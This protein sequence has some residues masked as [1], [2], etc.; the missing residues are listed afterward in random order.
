MALIDKL[1]AI[2]DAIR[3]KTGTT[4]PMTLD[5]MVTAIA[6]ITT[7]S[8]PSDT[9]TL[10]D[11]TELPKPTLKDGCNYAI[12]FKNSNYYSMLETSN[13]FANVNSWISIANSSYTIGTSNTVCYISRLPVNFNE[14][15]SWS[16]PTKY[17]LSNASFTTL[18]TLILSNEIIEKWSSTS[19]N[20]KV[21][22][23]NKNC[24]L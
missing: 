12:I 20:T 6:N 16:E 21:I 1:T 8:V 14:Y 3:S 7:G 5:E 22:Y 17:D 18:G 15:N 13:R 10:D 19:D 2:A 9:I 4:E 11:G 24:D 23:F